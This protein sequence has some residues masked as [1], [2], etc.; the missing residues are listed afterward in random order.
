MDA[1]ALVAAVAEFL[2]V[3]HVPE[4]IVEEMLADT[5]DFGIASEATRARLL[6]KHPNWRDP[7]KFFR[8]TIVNAFRCKTW[9]YDG[10]FHRAGDLPAVVFANGDKWW[11]WMGHRH[12]DGGKPAITGRR[13]AEYY[14]KGKRVVRVQPPR[15]AKRR[16]AGQ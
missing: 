16:R 12:R 10:K 15:A 3:P 9:C 4:L 2:P 11:Y 7:P 13:G 5:I 6:R 8:Y 14:V 1:D